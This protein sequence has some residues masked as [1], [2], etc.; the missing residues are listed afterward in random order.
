[1]TAELYFVN[2]LSKSSHVLYHRLPIYKLKGS[3]WLETYRESAS[4]LENS[5]RIEFISDEEE[6]H[7][8]SQ[9]LIISATIRK[10]VSKWK[11]CKFLFVL[12]IR[13]GKDFSRPHNAVHYDLYWATVLLLIEQGD[14][15]LFW[16]SIFLKS[17][18]CGYKLSSASKAI[19]ICV[20]AIHD[21]QRKTRPRGLP[22]WIRVQADCCLSKVF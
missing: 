2:L 17:I 9:F 20:C 21:C 10:M 5:L 4:Q 11:V 7:P 6:M 19:Q 3:T 14:K 22:F 12:W 18:W 8:W 1:M 16:K 15:R 13:Q